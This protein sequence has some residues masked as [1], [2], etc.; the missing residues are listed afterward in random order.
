MGGGGAFARGDGVLMQWCGHGGG[1]CFVRTFP[2]LNALQAVEKGLSQPKE[3][4]KAASYVGTLQVVLLEGLDLMGKDTGIKPDPFCDVQLGDQTLISKVIKRTNAPKWNQSLLFS[5]PTLDA[6]VRITV[7]DYD[8]VI[9]PARAHSDADTVATWADANVRSVGDVCALGGGVAQF[10]EPAFLGTCTVD[11][12]FL[13]YYSKPET[14]RME[15]NLTGVPRGKL[16]LQ[17]SFKSTTSGSTASPI[18]RTSTS[19]STSAPRRK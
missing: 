15:V 11:L 13:E 8:E 14:E 9:Y 3:R 2:P 5:V 10:D 17:L 6:S 18:A 19:G 1:G 12:N 7:K 16:A 4:G